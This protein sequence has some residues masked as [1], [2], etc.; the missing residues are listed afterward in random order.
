MITIASK[1]EIYLGPTLVGDDALPAK[2][3][4]IASRS[5]DASL[6]IRADKN[7]TAG[8]VVYVMDQAKLAGLSQLSFAIAP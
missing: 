6:A 2:L 5:K 8:R 7:V 4:E 3:R 1:G